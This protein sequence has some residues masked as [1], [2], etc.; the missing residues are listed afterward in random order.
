MARVLVTG[1]TGFIGRNLVERLVKGGDQVVCLLHRRG[2]ENFFAPLQV[3]YVRG[4]LLTPGSLDP[5]LPGV[6]I[7]YHLAG[8]TLVLS[9]KEF[10]RGNTEATRLLAEACAR[11]ERPPRVVFVSSLAAA[12][13]A[14]ADRPLTEESPAAP[15]SE[16]GR[17]KLAAEQHLRAVADRVPIT[18]VRPPIVFGPWDPLTVILFKIVRLGINFNA[19]LKDYRLAWIHVADLVEGL[20]KAARNG[21]HL[22]PDTRTAPPGR[23]IYFMAMDEMR[24]LREASELTARALKRKML[25]FI[26]F[27]AFLCRFLAKV[28]DRIAQRI[29]RPSLM[30]PDKIAE[31][32]AGSWM[33]SSDKA[34][35]ELGFSCHFQLEAGLRMLAQWYRKH[36]WM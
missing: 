23:G 6:D 21:E 1:A 29:S 20:V 34:K 10:A 25:A 2:A 32:L 30:V 14:P 12:G 33:C 8:A 11:Q 17:S 9:A 4:D 16:Y 13:V 19:G 22:P 3:E 15:V 7:V 36:G 5:V 35:R 28:N 26:Y 18:I 31:G 24:S 27:P